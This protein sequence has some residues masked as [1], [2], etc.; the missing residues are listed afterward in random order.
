[1]HLKK[2][3]FYN[4]SGA[5]LQNMHFFP[6]FIKMLPRRSFHQVESVMFRQLSFLREAD[7]TE[8]LFGFVFERL[9]CSFALVNIDVIGY[10]FGHEFLDIKQTVMFRGLLWFFFSLTM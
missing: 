8:P 3:A 1:M 9:G 10:F 4:V 2:E 6:T 7:K 5:T